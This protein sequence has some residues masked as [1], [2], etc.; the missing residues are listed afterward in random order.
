MKARTLGWTAALVGL[1]CLTDESFTSHTATAS[2]TAPGDIPPA[3]E[4]L[5]R[6]H[7]DRC[8]GLDWSILAAVGWQETHH[9]TLD[10]PGV[11]S[12]ENGAGAGG[13]MQFLDSTWQ[14]VRA[15][16]PGIGVSKYDPVNAIPAAAAYLC[17]YGAAEGDVRSALYQY[18]HSTEYVNAVLDQARAYR[19]GEDS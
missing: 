17:K 15:G 7:G 6:Q 11:T 3:Y 19:A 12:G 1:V 16:N 4:Q 2:S 8:A 9:G 13:P 18:N 5:Y 14:E 10:M